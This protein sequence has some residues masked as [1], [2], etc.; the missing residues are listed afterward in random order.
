MKGG[1][2]GSDGHGTEAAKGPLEF[3]KGQFNRRK[4][5]GIGRQEEEGDAEVFGKGEAGGR[6]VKGNVIKNDYHP[7][8]QQRTEA[9]LKV[10]GKDLR[11]RRAVDKQG[12]V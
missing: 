3:A 5:R 1:M 7:R 12:G 11:G 4:V 10:G 9:L 2:E 8:S 6:F